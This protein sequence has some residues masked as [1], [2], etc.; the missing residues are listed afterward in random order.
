M[1]YC[2]QLWAFVHDTSYD[3]STQRQGFLQRVS[4]V[5]SQLFAL[6]SHDAMLPGSTDPDAA[7][8]CIAARVSVGIILSSERMLPWFERVLGH[9]LQAQTASFNKQVE[10]HAQRG[11]AWALQREHAMPIVQCRRTLPTIV[12]ALREDQM[13]GNHINN[14]DVVLQWVGAYWNS[15]FMY[16]QDLLFG[17]QQGILSVTQSHLQNLEASL[18]SL[19]SSKSC[20][21]SW[22]IC[23]GCQG[24]QML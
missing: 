15:L 18:L 5:F 12:K 10:Q 19:R 22:L 4:T 16:P 6:L 23:R 2:R 9:E 7:S 11:A 24:W 1:V 13:S 8:T 20:G 14:Y 21:R 3:D 17:G